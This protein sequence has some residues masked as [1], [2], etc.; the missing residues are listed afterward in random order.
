M[1]LYTKTGDDG[2]TGLFG[3]QRVLKCDARVAAYGE[4]DEL[5]AA[6]GCAVAACSN[7]GIKEKLVAIQSDLFC[8]GAELATPPEK[9]DAKLRIEDCLAVKLEGWIDEASAAVPELRNFILPGGTALAGQLHLARAV[10]RR[11]ERMVVAL[12]ESVNAHSSVIIYLN[13][14]SD[15]LFALARLENHLSRI[16]ETPWHSR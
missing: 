7:P 6:L 9:L 4:V 10:C 2:T 11:A 15:L 5:N 16:Q 14:L 8:V 1:K 3:G 12:N 13:R